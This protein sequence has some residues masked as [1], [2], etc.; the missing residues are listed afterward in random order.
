MGDLAHAT[1]V[2]VGIAVAILVVLFLLRA[3]AGV[4]LIVFAGVLFAILL[5]S[6]SDWLAA[7][8]PLSDIWSL[9]VVILLLVGVVGVGGW[10]LAPEV[11]QQADQLLQNLPR[12]VQQLTQR[13]E[14]Y[15]W[16]RRILEETPRAAEQ[17]VRPGGIISGVTVFFSTTIGMISITAI[18]AFI[19]LYIAINPPLYI[20][21]FIRLVP[22]SR[23][24]RA[25]EVLTQ[26]GHILKWWLIGRVIAM[27]AIGVLTAL[28]LWLI[29]LQPALTLGVLAGILNFIPYIGP[30][31]SVVPPLLI[32]LTQDL[33]QAAYVTILYIV[34]QSFESYLLTPVIERRVILLPPALAVAVQIFLAVLLGI[35]GVMLASPLTA[36]IM[37]LVQTIYI[38]DI[39]GDRG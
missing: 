25:R 23:R 37:V 10:F 18:I 9:V 1:L 5:R 3:A 34:I 2:V 24:G 4:L 31:L 27:I 20:E 38:E 13:L 21:G 32:A 26:V 12:M 19:G 15:A 11:A 22:I 29:D 28:G 14:Q 8:T 33:T 7:H 36:T 16:G 17:L 30:V 6:L 35:P 39:L